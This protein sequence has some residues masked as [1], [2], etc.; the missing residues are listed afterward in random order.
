MF[1]GSADTWQYVPETMTQTQKKTETEAASNSSFK[2]LGV[3]FFSSKENEE[4]WK[5]VSSF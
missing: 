5:R 2:N 4:E 3:F 1:I